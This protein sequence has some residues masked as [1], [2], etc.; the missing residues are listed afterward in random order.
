MGC[1]ANGGFSSDSIEHLPTNEGLGNDSYWVDELA[2]PIGEHNKQTES[3]SSND[4][5]DNDT[6][7]IGLGE[8]Y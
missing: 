2:I 5:N 8:H 1:Q 4:D 6:N 3:N 7:S